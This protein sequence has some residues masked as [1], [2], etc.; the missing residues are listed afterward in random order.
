MLESK[1]LGKAEVCVKILELAGKIVPPPR[2]TLPGHP[3][4]ISADLRQIEVP[5]KVLNHRATRTKAKPK[6]KAVESAQKAPRRPTKA[7]P[8]TTADDG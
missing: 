4:A 6:A 8:G 3:A 7:H 2:D 1:Q 5:A